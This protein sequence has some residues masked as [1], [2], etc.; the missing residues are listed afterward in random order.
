MSSPVTERLVRPVCQVVATA[1]GVDTITRASSQALSAALGAS[2]VIENQPGAGGIVGTSA[3]RVV[4]RLAVTDGAPVGDTT[5]DSCWIF[6]RL[7]LNRAD[8]TLFVEKR[9]GLGYTLNLGN[10]WSWLVMAS[11]AFAIAVPFLLGT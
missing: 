6:G 5:P 2:V 4:R 11:F 7:Y 1:S 3:I 8:P 10:P 9:M